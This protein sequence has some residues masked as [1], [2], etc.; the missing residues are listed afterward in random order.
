MSDQSAST[1]TEAAGRTSCDL[2]RS[3]GAEAGSEGKRSDEALLSAAAADGRAA[4]GG[5]GGGGGG[6]RAR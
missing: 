2:P 1:A 4:A 3:S 6:L 5:G